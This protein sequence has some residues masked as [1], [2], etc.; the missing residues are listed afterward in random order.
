[1]FEEDD[2]ETGY[3]V[4]L[5]ITL[6]IV[7]SL[8]VIAIAIGTVIGQAG[9]KPASAAATAPSVVRVIAL[10]YFELGK[11]DPPADVMTLLAPAIRAAHVAADSKLVI[12]GYH[13]A[14]GDAAADA[15]LAKRR[16][17]AVRD[18]LAAAGVR[19]Q[20]IELAKPVVV[21]G[22]TDPNEARRVEVTLR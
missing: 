14:R 12:S 5:A 20:R 19:E 4:F 17:M 15:G 3:A 8:F 11:A 2:K 18:V 10:V 13:D 1:V 21:L 22:S 7:V 9:R 6:A 16:A